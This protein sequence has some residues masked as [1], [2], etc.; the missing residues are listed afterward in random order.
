MYNPE[1]VLKNEM[2][3]LLLNFEIQ[4]YPQNSARRPDLV[5]VYKKG[6]FDVPVE[7]RVKFFKKR[8]EREINM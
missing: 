5:I 3:K 1:S 6:D 4:I 2:H 8:R 7:H